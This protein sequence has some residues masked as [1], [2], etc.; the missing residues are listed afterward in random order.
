MEYFVKNK[1]LVEYI[2]SKFDKSDN[3]R[4]KSACKCK[5]VESYENM[6]RQQ[7]E[8]LFKMPSAPTLAPEPDPRPATR[9]KMPMCI[10]ALIPAP[11]P[12]K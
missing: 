6:S 5:K 4:I 3:R 8:S 11:R 12:T 1:I 2:N 9:P 10:S 7:L